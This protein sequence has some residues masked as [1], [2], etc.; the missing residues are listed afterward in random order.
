MKRNEKTRSLTRTYVVLS[1]GVILIAA[2]GSE[3]HD[4]HDDDHQHDRGEE[5]YHND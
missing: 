4:D 5:T 1:V 2:S 3:M